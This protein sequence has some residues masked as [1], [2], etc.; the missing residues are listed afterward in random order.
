MGRVENIEDY[1]PLEK[2]EHSGLYRVD[3]RNFSLGVYNEKDK[4]FIGI[5][6]KFTMVFLDLEFHWDT[7]APYGTVKPSEFLEWCPVYVDE[8]NDK[9][10]EWLKERREHYL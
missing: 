3:A 2:C 7:G 9:L 6:T 5:R 4:G 8:K 1:L 10:F